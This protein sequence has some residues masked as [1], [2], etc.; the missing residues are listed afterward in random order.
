MVAK[1][2]P[3][4]QHEK[5][6][7]PWG[8]MTPEK[9]YHMGKGGGRYDTEGGMYGHLEF[10]KTGVLSAANSYEAGIKPKDSEEVPEEERP[11]SVYKD[12]ARVAIGTVLPDDKG[13]VEPG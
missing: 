13:L 10:G 8:S 5:C 3:G 7:T 4:D 12:K 9:W 11:G 1:S 6:T 2:A